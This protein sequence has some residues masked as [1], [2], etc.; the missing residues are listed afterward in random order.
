MTTM[1]RNR[2]QILASTF[3]LAL[4]W[5]VMMGL[6]AQETAVD[7]ESTR[8]AEHESL[9]IDSLPNAIRVHPRVISGGLPEGVAGFEALQT[10]GVRTVISVDGMKP[11]VESAR[12]FGLRYVHLPH[13]YD[14]VPENRRLELARAILDFPG[15]IYIHCHHGKHRSPA[16]TASAC[17]TA[18]LMSGDDGARLLKQAGTSPDYAGLFRSV[19][20]AQRVDADE[21]AALEM[22]YPEVA[23]IP[24]MAQAMVD[25]DHA[26]ADV[27][28]VQSAGWKPPADHP[29]LD[30]GH[31]V[32]MLREQLTELVRTDESRQHG[33]RFLGILDHS[34][35]QSQA[36]QRSLKDSDASG[37]FEAAAR[38][39]EAIRSDCKSCHQAFRD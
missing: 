25:L 3:A 11:D 37:G 19:D 18:G 9:S 33:D 7:P 38:A 1:P 21:L 4:V 26:F 2:K 10:L 13:G 17:I 22:E 6:H 35:R 31:A 32:L 36:L 16:A 24:P 23:K 14:R 30:P 15:P 27:L 34:I 5:P 29:D 28:S 39:V 8:M 12:R 20:Q